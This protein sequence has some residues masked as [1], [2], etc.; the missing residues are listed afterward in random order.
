MLANIEVHVPGNGICVDNKNPYSPACHVSVL[1]A[2]AIVILEFIDP[3]EYTLVYTVKPAQVVTS[4]KKS[5]V[6]KDHH[7][8]ALLYNFL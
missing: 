4:V 2:E 1:D 6:L 7:F 8:I 5:S 3:I